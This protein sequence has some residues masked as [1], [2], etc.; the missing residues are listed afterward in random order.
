MTVAR[1]RAKSEQS[2]RD[3][4]V[5][6]LLARLSM[7]RTRGQRKKAYLLAVLASSLRERLRFDLHKRRERTVISWPARVAALS[8]HRAW[9]GVVAVAVLVERSDR[10]NRG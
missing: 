6:L 8:E 10:S 5:L 9:A 2:K 4:D 3:D 1:D 7:R